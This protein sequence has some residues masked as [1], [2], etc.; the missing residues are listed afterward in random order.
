MPAQ[1][2]DGRALAAH[3]RAQVKTEIQKAGITPG[4][5]AILV[6]ADPASHLYVGL[7]EK[8][9]AEVGIHFEKYLFFATEPQEKIIAK[10]HELNQRRDIHAIL[11][12]LP[13]P[14]NFDENAVIRVVNHKK[15]VDGFHPANLAALAEGAPIII[16]GVSAGIMALIESSGTPLQG[17]RTALLV[18]SATFALPV[19]YLLKKQG[20]FVEIIIAPAD[21]ETVAPKLAK[22]DIM[23]TAIGRPQAV[24]ND[25]IKCGAIVIDVGTNRL[26]TGELV[27]DVDVTAA[28]EKAGFVTPVPGG[29]G[30]MT[31]AMLLKNVLELARR[32]G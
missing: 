24:K 5:A 19:E 31:V 3:V 23:I 28:N 8:A 27:G 30:P 18:N 16:P 4:L 13:L 1:F 15:D 7:K 25:M 20:V 14:S 2:L 11:V 22:A 9:A 6:G 26:P 10:I 12:Q 17:K 32:S 21:L 29:V